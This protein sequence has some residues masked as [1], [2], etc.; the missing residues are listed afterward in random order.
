MAI[1]I[2]AGADIPAEFNAIIEIPAGG[3]EVKYEFDKEAGL[4]AVDRFMPTSMRYPC[5][6]GFVPST[7]AEDGDPADV[8]V[9]TPCPVVPGSLMR[10]RPIGVL[11]MADESGEDS[12]ILAVPIVKACVQLADV[13]SL[14]DVSPILLKTIAHFF[15]HYKDLE[16]GKWVKVKG[17]EDKAAAEKELQASVKR[18]LAQRS[19]V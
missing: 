8:L 19:L 4:I 16:S 10:V 13:Q 9:I 12:K 7:L 1:H 6:Y 18:Y 14:K 2:A 3:G 15:E 11:N 5:N 17:W